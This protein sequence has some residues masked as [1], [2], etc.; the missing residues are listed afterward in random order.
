MHG[1]Q[2][3]G[4]FADAVLALMADEPRRQAMGERGRA[5]VMANADTE[6]VMRALAPLLGF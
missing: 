3:A 5:Y 1:A 4:K 2:A 6:V